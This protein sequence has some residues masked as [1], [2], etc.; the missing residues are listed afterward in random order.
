MPLQSFVKINKN[1]LYEW[2]GLREDEI[3]L[4][5]ANCM[6]LTQHKNMSL[7]K[8]IVE[9]FNNAPGASLNASTISIFEKKNMH[10]V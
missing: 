4:T 10:I 1:K 9:A 3:I 5:H 2:L 8:K 6:H 7:Q